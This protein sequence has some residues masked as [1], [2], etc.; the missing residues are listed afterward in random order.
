M[1]VFIANHNPTIAIFYLNHQGCSQESLPSYSLK[2]QSFYNQL[3]ENSVCKMTFVGPFIVWGFFKQLLSSL[4]KEQVLPGSDCSSSW[5]KKKSFAAGGFE[6]LSRKLLWSS[7][8]AQPSA[9]E[10]EDHHPVSLTFISW[11]GQS[12]VNDWFK[13]IFLYGTATETTPCFPPSKI[14][15]RD[16]TDELNEVW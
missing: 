5:E 13:H 6:A 3:S 2:W 15:S 11:Q 14:T 8:P 9:Q 7:A 10:P 12:S 1:L 4:A 16:A